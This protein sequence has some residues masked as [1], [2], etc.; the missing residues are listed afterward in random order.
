MN[1]TQDKLNDSLK[2]EVLL[3]HELETEKRNKSMMQMELDTLTAMINESD[4]NRVE[5]DSNVLIKDCKFL[6][7]KIYKLKVHTFVNLCNYIGKLNL[8]IFNTC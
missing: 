8:F 7:N 6:T 5:S 1:H 2:R 3:E 4:K